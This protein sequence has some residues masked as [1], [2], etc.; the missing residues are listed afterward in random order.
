MAISMGTV[1][2]T[3]RINHG[4]ISGVSMD[5]WDLLFSYPTSNMEV[6]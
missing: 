5:F 4:I 2:G 6:S 3:M 1:S